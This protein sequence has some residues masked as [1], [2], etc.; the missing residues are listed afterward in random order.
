MSQP[1][2]STI[3]VST[4]DGLAVTVTTDGPITITPPAVTP[5]VTPPPGAS[6]TI[7]FDDFT[8]PAGAPPNPA[9]WNALNTT[10]GPQNPEA[11]GG[12]DQEQYLANMVALDGSAAGTLIFTVGQQGGNGA[13]A[14][15]WPSGRV[16][17]LHAPGQFYNGAFA[18]HGNPPKVAVLP[19]Q[20]CEFSM[21][22]AP[23]AGLW[24]SLWFMCPGVPG[25]G[26]PTDYFEFDEAEFGLNGLPGITRCTAWGPGA[27][28]QQNLSAKATGGS[29]PAFNLDD[30]KYHTYRLDYYPDRL[31]AYIDGVL[32]YEITEAQVNAAFGP[33]TGLNAQFG[34]QEWPY[35][36]PNEGLC[37]IMNC[38][39]NPH[40][41]GFTP[42]AG[43]LPHEVMY[44]DWVRV[45]SPAGPYVA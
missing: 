6:T 31:A 25:G 22:A 33:Q 36:Q 37:I 2:V 10:S 35:N 42:A 30:G 12:G 40:V 18:T 1:T 45:H 9:Y 15:Y 3:T 16:D 26:Y 19:G 20:S 14:G 27:S 8:G 38:A 23:L 44:V 4:A 28:A 21:K 17:S 34:G 5:P 43:S 41:T 39:V 24:P 7:M 13:Q 11:F 32:Q 29:G